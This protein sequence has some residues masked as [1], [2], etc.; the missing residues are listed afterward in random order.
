M[1]TRGAITF[2][3]NGVEKTCYNHFDSYPSGLGTTMLDWLRSPDWDLDKVRALVAALRMVDEE[4]TPTDEER[5]RYAQYA[6]TC[7][8]TGKDWYALLRR[9]QGNPAAILEAGVAGDSEEFP[10]DS[11]FCEWVYVV[12][13]DREVFEVYEGYQKSRPT[14][15]RWATVETPGKGGYW[16]VALLFS[17]PIPEIQALGRSSESHMIAVERLAAERSEDVP[18]SDLAAGCIY[19]IRSRNLTWAV[20]RGDGRFQGLREKFGV[21][22]LDVELLDVTVTRVVRK[23]GEIDVSVSDG[24]TLA[25]LERIDREMAS[26]EHLANKD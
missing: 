8:S 5:E 6:D 9:T 21:H 4:A 3:H 24:Q 10:L 17:W 16:P 12:D 22:R 23:V 18:T 25:I 11:L 20:Y 14:K 13:L 15:G 1:G 7:V 26:T 19:E 2:V